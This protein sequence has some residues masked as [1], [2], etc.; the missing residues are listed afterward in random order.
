MHREQVPRSDGSDGGG[1]SSGGDSFGG[2]SFE[3]GASSGGDA[4][5]TPGPDSTPSSFS[6]AL[7]ADAIDQHAAWD[8][9]CD[10][11]SMADGHGG[12]DHRHAH[13][14]PGASGP[15]S[16]AWAR[17]TPEPDL[18]TVLPWMFVGHAVANTIGAGG[19]RTGA[20]A[21][22]SPN[23]DPAQGWA[24]I[25]SARS[26]LEAQMI[27]AALRDAGIESLCDEPM[28]MPLDDALRQRR[29]RVQV[30]VPARQEHAAQAAL[31]RHVEQ[32]RAIDWDT[33]DVGERTDSI[34][35]RRP[36]SVP[37]LALVVAVVALVALV[38]MVV[39]AVM[40]LAR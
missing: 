16:V 24:V 30:R 39:T 4:F 31:R 9:A 20:P 40:I 19:S 12:S 7:S 29:M 32:A 33:V 34:V 36:G 3:G 22:A 8:A 13:G 18:A 23:V 37:I 10:P 6:D 27:V 25:A 14:D 5:S 35:G 26:Q 17:D 2:S 11:A 38:V 28:L 21:S 1:G 15:P